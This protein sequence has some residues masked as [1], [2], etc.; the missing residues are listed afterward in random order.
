MILVTGAAGFIGFSLCK[1]LLEGNNK[2]IGL[3][4]LNSYYSLRLKKDR[5]NILQKYKTFEFIKCDIVDKKQLQKKINKKKIKIIYH[6]AAQAGVRHSLKYPEDY[7]SNNLVGFFNVIEIAKEKKIKH[8]IFSSTSSVY[9]LNKK[10]PFKVSSAV[11]HPSQ[12]Y[13]ATKRSNELMAHSYS[14]MYNLPITVFR[15]F[16]V[17]GPWGRPDM[18]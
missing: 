8:F 9:G 18:A 10:I 3:D 7:V 6:L 4:N 2:V 17:Y 5:L 1:K 11:D 12:F 13:A 16:S 15:F 14:Y